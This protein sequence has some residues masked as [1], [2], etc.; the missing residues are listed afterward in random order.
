MGLFF[1]LVAD[2]LTSCPGAAPAASSHA[3]D[4][5]GRHGD[6]CYESFSFSSPQQENGQ[7]VKTVTV[8]SVSTPVMCLGQSVHSLDGR[9]V[10]AGCGTRV[11]SFTADYDVCKTID[12]RPNLVFQ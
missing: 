11:L 10:W 12:T 6:A 7:P 1:G 9:S 5:H 3:V 4:L 8:G 2:A